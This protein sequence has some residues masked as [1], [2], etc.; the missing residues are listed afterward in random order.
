MR[1]AAVLVLLLFLSGCNSESNDS[2]TDKVLA[3]FDGTTITE[4][5]F[6]KKAEGLPRALQNVAMKRKKELIE[7]MVAEHFLLRE[8][9][10]QRLNKDPDV[11]DLIRVA[12]KK[13]TIAKLVEKE[14][15]RKISILPDEV[16]QYYEFHQDEFMTPLL[17][18]ASHILVKTE[19]EAV[20]VKEALDQGADFE[21]TARQKSIDTT[22]VRGGDLGY[23]Q[24]GQFVSE[25]EEAALQM[26]KGE[27]R[28]PV[29]SQFGYHV[30]RLNDR[31]EPRL[32][33][34]RSVKN[35]VEERLM[36]ER[37]AKMF[38]EFVEKLKG[39]TR[40]EIDDKALE[41]REVKP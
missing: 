3:R 13:I 14:I 2:S 9:E 38:K 41:M 29:K 21:E 33:D 24:K 16:S 17:F 7:D 4:R 40:V 5:D 27:I 37:R 39:N 20:A 28:G 12:Q 1:R 23:F 32:R 31:V 10:R 8:A 36:N 15:D 25:F 34:F 11:Q 35:R 18:R 26:K 22:A 6:L 30:I 19:E